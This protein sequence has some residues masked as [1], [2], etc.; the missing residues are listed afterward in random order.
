MTTEK[1]IP[2]IIAIAAIISLPLAAQ[3]TPFPDITSQ[4]LTLNVAAFHIAGQPFPNTQIDALPSSEQHLVLN[5]KT[6]RLHTLE[7][8]IG[9]GTLLLAK[10][11]PETQPV[12]LLP[13][14]PP[15]SNNTHPPFPKKTPR[16]RPPHSSLPRHLVG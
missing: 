3:E 11:P 6:R 12:T 14:P 10:I 4:G 13:P 9:D 5:L 8:A 16:T 15:A 7:R 1:H 2:A